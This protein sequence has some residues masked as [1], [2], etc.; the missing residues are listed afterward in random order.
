MII[1]VVRGMSF[2]SFFGIL[3][4]LVRGDSRGA[5]FVKEDGDGQ[6]RRKEI[7]FFCFISSPS[8]SPAQSPI[9]NEFI[10]SP[11]SLAPSSCHRN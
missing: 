5:F 4:L 7:D 2:S 6:L 3:S 9:R 11:D 1:R 8:T 10:T